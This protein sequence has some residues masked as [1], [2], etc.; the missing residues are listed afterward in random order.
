MKTANIVAPLLNDSSMTTVRMVPWFPWELVYFNFIVVKLTVDLKFHSNSTA[1]LRF[2]L[3]LLCTTTLFDRLFQVFFSAI[4][5]SS[6]TKYWLKT[7][8]YG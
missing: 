3:L 1:F 7:V 8:G 6:L 5:D 4:G 2:Q